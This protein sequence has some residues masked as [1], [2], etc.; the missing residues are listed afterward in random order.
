M[1]SEIGDY[2]ITI[3]VTDGIDEVSQQFSL[4]VTGRG[5]QD[6]DHT[7]IKR[8][9]GFSPNGDGF[10]D[11][12]YIEGLEEYPDNS[13]TVFNRWGNKVY[14]ASPYKNDWNGESVSA[15]S[16]GKDLS[17]GTYYYI[18]DLGKA[19]GIIKGYVYIQK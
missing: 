4:R 14:Y 2:N 19:A 1:V 7:D 11:E 10:N 13:L 3:I 17:T 18:L 16:I 6:N 12:F 8:P 5:L 9:E 15:I